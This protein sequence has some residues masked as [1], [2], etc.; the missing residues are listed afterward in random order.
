MRL[1]HVNNKIGITAT[2]RIETSIYALFF[3]RGAENMADT[4]IR[5]HTLNQMQGL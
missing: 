5:Q 1:S 4:S 3:L 2:E